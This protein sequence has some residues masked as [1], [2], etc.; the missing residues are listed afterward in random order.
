[1]QGLI[2]T[3]QKDSVREISNSESLLCFFISG[4]QITEGSSLV[5][6]GGAL[7]QSE[8]HRASSHFTRLHLHLE[9]QK[10]YVL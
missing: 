5:Y 9:K 8:N 1:V 7:S 3:D 2:A 6:Y 10:S 4:L